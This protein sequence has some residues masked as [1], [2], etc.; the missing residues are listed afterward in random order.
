MASGDMGGSVG[1]LRVAYGG[2]RLRGRLACAGLRYGVRG[3]GSL[4]HCCDIHPILRYSFRCCNCG[5]TQ[6]ALQEG[7]GKSEHSWVGRKCVCRHK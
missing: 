7:E 5:A 3:G 1:F 2:V 4:R 6:P